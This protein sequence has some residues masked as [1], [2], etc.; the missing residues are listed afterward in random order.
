MGNGY[1][2]KWLWLLLPKNY[3]ERFTAENIVN[4]KITLISV[5]AAK[6]GTFRSKH[7]IQRGKYMYFTITNNYYT[8]K[9]FLCI[10]Y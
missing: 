8:L 1:I 10:L 3:F 5:D 4:L 9:F 6:R 2:S 7:I